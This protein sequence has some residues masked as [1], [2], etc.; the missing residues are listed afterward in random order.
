MGDARPNGADGFSATEVAFAGF[1]LAR[2]DP[3][4]VVAWGLLALV[5]G[6]ISFGCM[7]AVLAPVFI[8]LR[9]QLG[10]GQ[11]VSPQ[12][13]AE[14]VRR[15]APLNLVSLVLSVTF[16]PLLLA[17]VYRAVLKPRRAFGHF[18][19]GRDEFIQLLALLLVGVIFLAVYVAVVFA[20]IAGAAVLYATVSHPAGVIAGVA[21]GVIGFGLLVLLA[22]KLSLVGPASFDKG[23]LQL[24]ASWR[25]TRGRFWPL[26]GAYL[27]SVV[28]VMLTALGFLM[29]FAIVVLLA[30]M[31][32]GAFGLQTA[33]ARYYAVAGV[34]L[35]Y[36]LAV[37]LLNG[38]L[39]AVIFAPAAE[40]YRRLT[41]PAPPPEPGS[42]HLFGTPL[43]G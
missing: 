42:S 38:L 41:E 43:A 31:T 14:L 29:V 25:L 37:S 20:I 21:G 22:V 9:G 30:V 6:L 17:A 10:P 4:S 24:G 1:H 34:F 40:A 35:A 16:Y 5:M 2:R 19:V 3:W 13:Q 32:A 15:V 26:L 36:V 39:Y 8:D 28:M 18:R 23:S 33:P 11:T 27:L 7:A 12:T